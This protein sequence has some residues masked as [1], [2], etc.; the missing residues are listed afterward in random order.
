MNDTPQCPQRG[1]YGV[2]LEPGRYFWCSCG[3]SERQPFCDGS[4]KPTAFTPVAIDIEMRTTIWFCG[5]K[6]TGASPRCDGSHDAMS[7]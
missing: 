3:L 1:P 2:E 6:Q 4:H 7:G 5:C